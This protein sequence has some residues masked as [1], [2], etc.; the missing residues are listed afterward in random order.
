MTHGGRHTEGLRPRR[1]PPATTMPRV[2]HSRCSRADD[3]RVFS[4]CG[5]A[6]PPGTAPQA[7]QAPPR[8]PSN[9][10]RLRILVVRTFHPNAPRRWRASVLGGRGRGGAGQV[11]RHMEGLRPRRPRAGRGSGGAA[12]GGPPSSEA[13]PA[14][15]MPRVTHSRCSRADDARVFSA[16]GD[17]GPPGTAPTTACGDAGPPCGML[18]ASRRTCA[19]LS[20]PAASLPFPCPLAAPS[21]GACA[22]LSL[23]TPSSGACAPLPSRP[24]LSSARTRPTA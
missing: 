15:T 14:T 21:S 17:A 16:C 2:T 5:D 11:A 10:Q 20:L 12:H 1:P 19:R 23:P 3:A 9:A 13:A 6:G 24:S 18:T 4:A 22:Q 8:R 7:L